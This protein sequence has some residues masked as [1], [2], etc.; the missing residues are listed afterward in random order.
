MI[1]RVKGGVI[2]S[3]ISTAGYRGEPVNVANG[4]SNT[5]LLNFT[6]STAMKLVRYSI[7]GVNLTPTVTEPSE[8]FERGHRWGRSVTE[9]DGLATLK[10]KFSRRISM[11]ALP[12]PSDYA[13]ALAFLVSDGAAMMTGSDLRIDV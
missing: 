8:M 5:G 6:R 3:I 7:R 2:V 13:R 1:A 11:Q 9:P 10:G 12:K 4:T